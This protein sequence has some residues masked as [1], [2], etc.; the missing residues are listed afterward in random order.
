MREK[1]KNKNNYDHNHNNSFHFWEDSV[2]V[3]FTTHPAKYN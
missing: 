1:A 2:D 3:L